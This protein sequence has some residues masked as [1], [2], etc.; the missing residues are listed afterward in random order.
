M[1][2]R[3]HLAHYGYHLKSRRGKEGSKKERK[4]RVRKKKKREEKRKI[5][6]YKNKTTVMINYQKQTNKKIKTNQ[7]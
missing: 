3:N 4:S 6:K 7:Q 1:S 5:K 2:H